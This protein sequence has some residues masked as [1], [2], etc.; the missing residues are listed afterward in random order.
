MSASVF[1]LSACSGAKAID[2]VVTC[3][4]IDE[5]ARADLLDQYPEATMPAESLYTGDEHEHVKAA[6][7]QF[8][9]IADIDWR[10]ISA[11]F[12]L[13]RP[14]TEL[15]SYECTF[16]DDDSVRS[17]VERMGYDSTD[18]TR[19]ERILMVAD[20]LGIATDI[21]RSLANEFDV[22]FVLLGKDYLLTTGTTLSSI[23]RDTS[24]FAF[25]AEGNRDLI[26]DCQWVPSTEKEREALGT[27]WTQVKGHQLR[28]VAN[29][30]RT[31]DDFTDLTSEML[32]E[33]SIRHSWTE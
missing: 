22:A 26:G 9:R 17:R 18:M 6:I 27:T 33:F 7:E 24:A 4:D 29:N 1:I 20:E 32:R 5:S 14:D 13:V 10:I 30:V 25:A 31:T 16:K 12:G 19:A 23:P 21:E 8:E 3:R 15:P 28:N 11:G 2:P